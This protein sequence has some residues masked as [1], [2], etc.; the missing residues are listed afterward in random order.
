VLGLLL[1]A[2]CSNA[3]TTVANPGQYLRIGVLPAYE[4]EIT[5]GTP[6]GLFDNALV[7][8]FDLDIGLNRLV[9]D[10]VKKSIGQGHEIVDFQ[11]FAAAYIGAPKVHAGG[12]RKI[13]GDSRPLFTDV[14]R[15]IIGAQGLDAYVLIEGGP[16]GLYEPRVAPAIQLFAAQGHNLGMQLTIYV[17]DGRTFEVAAVFRADG[18]RL[19]VPDAW[20]VSPKQHAADIKDAVVELLDQNLEPALRK[21]GLI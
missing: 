17:I 21:V 11:P 20:F 14:L 16:V 19:G 12:E 10:R 4:P 1:L 15:S 7:E 8:H 18:V 3:P 5:R 13:F 9:V 6:P 2:A